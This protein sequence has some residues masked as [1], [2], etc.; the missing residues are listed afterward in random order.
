MTVKSHSLFSTDQARASC[1]VKSCINK[2]YSCEK[3]N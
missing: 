1:I 2:I 3:K